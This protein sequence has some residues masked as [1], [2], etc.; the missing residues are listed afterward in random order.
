M[1][2]STFQ[3]L[4]M[5]DSIHDAMRDGTVGRKWI[6]PVA[7]CLA[8]TIIASLLSLFVATQAQAIPAFARKYDVNC[9][10]CHTAPPILNTYGQRFLENGYQLP[11]TEDGGSTGK[12]KLGDLTLDDVN[13]YVGFR[14]NGN[15]VSSWGFKQQNPPGADAGVVDNK[16]EFTF[17]ENFVLFAGGTVAKNVGFMVELGHDAQEGG[18]AVERGFAPRYLSH[19]CHGIGWHAHAV[20]RRTVCRERRAT[21]ACGELHP[22][23]I[24]GGKTMTIIPLRRLMVTGGAWRVGYAQPAWGATDSGLTASTGAT[25]VGRVIFRGAVPPPEVVPVTRNP[26]TCGESQS[27]QTTIVDPASG[28]VKD[29]VVSLVLREGP[30]MPAPDQPSTI[31]TVTNRACA[32]HPRVGMAKAGDLL[33]TRNEDPVMHNTHIFADNRTFL[34]VALVAGGKPVQKKVRSLGLMKLTCDA[35]PFM[36]GFVMVS[37]HDFV[38]TTDALG[39]F[40]I[41]GVPPGKYEISL[42]H[43]RLGSLKKQV[44]VPPQGELSV[45]LQYP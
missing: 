33:E 35:H 9:T 4:Q 12:K 21:L 11:G 1:G 25:I 42:W 19:A 36:H 43:E 14:L 6:C 29:T 30:V 22:V 41:A 18:A 15:A 26:E 2:R 44:T 28:G 8:A 20:I 27:I 17:P 40:S 45:T 39:R 24:S 37:D 16:A 34:N 31:P 5:A 10:A 38:A 3:T 23:V 13:Q 32:F 7:V